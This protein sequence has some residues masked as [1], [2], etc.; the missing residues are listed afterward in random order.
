M[1]YRQLR[2]DGEDPAGPRSQRQ[3]S[4]QRTVDATA[5]RGHMWPRRTGQDPHCTVRHA[6]TLPAG[7]HAGI[8]SGGAQPR[9]KKT[10]S[11]E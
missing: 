5:R 9:L 2:G 11:H 1:L 4:G 3:R 6:D 8:Y 7:L 10:K